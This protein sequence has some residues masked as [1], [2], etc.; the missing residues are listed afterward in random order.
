MESN[1]GPKLKPSELRDFLLECMET[2]TPVMIWGYPGGGKSS[3]VNQIALSKKRLLHDIRVSQLESVDLR[4]LMRIN[5]EGRTEWCPPVFLP[6]EENSVLLLD[7]LNS[8]RPEVFAALYQLV[9]DGKVG[10]YRLPKGCWVVGTGN[11]EGDRSIVNRMPVALELRFAHCELIYDQL[12]LE[13]WF[14][15]TNQ[16]IELVAWNRFRPDRMAAY[17]PTSPDKGKPVPRQWVSGA[18]FI[19][20]YH[21]H[22]DLTRLTRAISSCVGE[23]DA[24]ECAA[25][26]ED[27]KLLPDPRKVLAAPEK[28]QIPKKLSVL[29][30]LGAALAKYVDKETVSAFYT[31]AGRLKDAGHAE[32]A[33]SMIQDALTRTPALQETAACSK[34][35]VENGHLYA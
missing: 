6:K 22:K 29:V 4:G 34:W 7:E 27:W 25:F 12:D 8:G 21:Q 11:R 14:I 31:Y 20:S 15:K 9:L 1:Y 13:Y 28:A 32:H 23:P 3:I 17:D 19:K 24:L 10:E 18:G 26:I 33:V 2:G 5:A 16:P 30:S 35:R